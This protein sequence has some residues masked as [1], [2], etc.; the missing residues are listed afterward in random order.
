LHESATDKQQNYL[1]KINRNVA[2]MLALI[3]D[4]LSVSKLETG[5]F[6]TYKEPISLPEYFAT[7]VD[8][9]SE[10]ITQKSIALQT[11]FNPT[12]YSIT[13]DSR[14][15]H[16]IVS[17][18]LSN[19]V[20]YVRPNDSISFTYQG[21]GSEVEIVIADSGI[22]IPP[23]ELPQLFSKFFRASNA[24]EHKAEGTGLGLYIVK[25]SVSKLGGTIE[26]TSVK[27]QGTK[28]VVRLPV[29]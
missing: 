27:D 11:N 8:E 12:P 26:V 9:Y 3:N 15:L 1:F 18:L 21:Y 10:P 2:R 13:T 4:F 28:F 24:K 25:E 5:S 20:K 29:A 14:L 22:G 6:S 16:I 23:E 7:I 19:A 17:N